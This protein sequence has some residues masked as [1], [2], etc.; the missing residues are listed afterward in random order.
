MMYSIVGYCFNK[1][2]FRPH[3]NNL[4]DNDKWPPPLSNREGKEDTTTVEEI[5][6][7]RSNMYYSIKTN[8]MFIPY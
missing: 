7:V 2:P 1:K 8:S 3:P 5:V 4:S 6:G